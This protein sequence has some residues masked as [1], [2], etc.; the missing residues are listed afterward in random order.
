M[1]WSANKKIHRIYSDEIKRACV[2]HM[3]CLAFE[4]LGQWKSYSQFAKYNLIIKFLCAQ[5]IHTPANETQHIWLMI[6]PFTY[7]SIHNPHPI[8]QQNSA[9]IEQS[10]EIYPWS[11]FLLPSAS[12]SSRCRHRK[13][14]PDR[15]WIFVLVERRTCARWRYAVAC[16]HGVSLTFIHINRLG[17]PWYL[18]S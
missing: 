10:I 2:A 6:S 5:Y 8:S 11:S 7:L 12:E 3:I 18:P 15:L 13:I 4:M 16:R 1:T 14:S 9:F 17:P